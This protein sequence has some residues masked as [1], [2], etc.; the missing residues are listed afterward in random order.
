MT[1]TDLLLRVE[2]LRKEYAAPGRGRTFRAVDDVSF[3]VARGET[4]ALVGESGC[5]KSTT[6][7][8]VLR[9][10]EPTAGRVLLGGDDIRTMSAAELRR[11]RARMQMVMQ[12]PRS[13]LDPR[14]AIRQSI[15][16]P[17]RSIGGR[18]RSEIARR[19][20]ECLDLVGLPSAMAD[21]YPHQLSGGQRQ[22]VGI[23]RAIATEPDLI[24][25]DEAVSALDVSVQVQVMNLLHDLQERLGIAYLFISH[26]MS[27]VRY[28]SDRVV[29]MYMG[30]TVESAPATEFFA[31]QAH[32]YSQALLSA[33]PSPTIGDRRERIVLSGDVPSPFARPSGCVFRT[34]CPRAEA[35]CAEEVPVPRD[36]AP[37]RVVSCH[38]PTIPVR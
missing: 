6:G 35:R 9:L 32:P 24:V 5:G 38:F 12:N 37:G 13:Q 16:E 20:E 10:V 33:V 21:R 28:L 14:M 22:R 18:G 11:Q 25:L 1:D 17:L 34:R 26:S 2:G 29:V 23:A 3:D 19:V 15:A 31:A 7:L 4:V 30:R 36:I 27:A 8:S